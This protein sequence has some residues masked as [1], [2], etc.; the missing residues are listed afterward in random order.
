MLQS[1]RL[2][3]E[4]QGAK[5][6]AVAFLFN[7]VVVASVEEVQKAVSS[8]VQRRVSSAAQNLDAV[9][10]QFNGYLD[11]SCELRQNIS[12]FAMRAEEYAHFHFR[13]HDRMDARSHPQ[14]RCWH[15]PAQLPVP[16]SSASLR[17]RASRNSGSLPAR[18]LL[19]G[20]CIEQK[21]SCASFLSLAMNRLTSVRR[22]QFT[23]VGCF[24]QVL[25]RTRISSLR[26][27]VPDARSY[28]SRYTM[29]RSPAG[30]LSVTRTCVF[31][32]CL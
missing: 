5:S 27:A 1:L 30:L 14:E 25:R 32:A 22:L 24:L 29:T 3:W 2:G 10:C 17:I 9:H 13:L 31:L 4:S 23:L 16:A 18:H 8:R 19:P 7:T 26:F 20:L 12:N 21:N 15:Q 28:G 6:S 11:L